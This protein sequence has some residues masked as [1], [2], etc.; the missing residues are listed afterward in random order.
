M[1]GPLDVARHLLALDVPHEVVHLT[2]RIES[3]YELPDVLAVPPD[4]C[5]ATELFEVD[6]GYVVTLV[7]CDAVVVPEWLARASG[8]TSVR[9]PDTTV[10][11]RITDFMAT[12]VPP[13]GLPESL[14]V[15]ADPRVAGTEVCY[16][17]TGDSGTALKVHGADLVRAANAALAEVS[18]P[19]PVPI[20]RV[21]A[22]TR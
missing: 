19:M 15:I 8:G 13:A 9:Q 18:K 7:P 14:P 12:L 2:R 16:A 20:P 17:A 22:V 5:L 11:S 3:A 4:S 21:A 1:R 6:G 10:I